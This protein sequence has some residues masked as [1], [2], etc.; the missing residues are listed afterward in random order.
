MPYVNAAYANEAI[1]KGGTQVADEKIYPLH[2]GPLANR[3]L[4]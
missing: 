4:R 2:V 3:A 1:A